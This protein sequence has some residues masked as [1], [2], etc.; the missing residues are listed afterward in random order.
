V[1]VVEMMARADEPNTPVIVRIILD[2][3]MKP[4]QVFDYMEDITGVNEA[5]LAEACDV[6]TG[7]QKVYAALDK[8]F[9][10]WAGACRTT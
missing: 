4:D 6:Q 1:S 3:K 5:M 9:C 2:L 10:W 7:I 8:Q